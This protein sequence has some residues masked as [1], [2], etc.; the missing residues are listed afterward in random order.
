MISSLMEFCGMRQKDDITKDLKKS[1]I[2]NSRNNLS[3]LLDFFK[4]C[5]NPFSADLSKEHLYNVSSGQSVDDKIYDF[6]SKVETNGETQRKYFF[7]TSS[8]NVKRFDQPITK[9]TICNF[10]FNSTKKVTILGQVKEVEVQR[11]VFG[12]LLY[13]TIEN[14]MDIEQALSFSLA[15]IS[16]SFCHANGNICKTPKSVVINELLKFQSDDINVLDADIHIF[17]GFYL[18]HTLTKI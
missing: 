17:D 2:K 8:T 18:L 13:A 7:T 11:D 3:A 4:E 9:N 1:S 14:K 5:T 10:A 15:P 6:L 16:F 12:R